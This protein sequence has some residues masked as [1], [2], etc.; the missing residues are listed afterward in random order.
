MVQV[1]SNCMQA[2]RKFHVLAA[3]PR[4]PGC[5]CSELRLLA[6]LVQQWLTS[7]WS[8]VSLQPC[9]MPAVSG[10]PCDPSTLVPCTFVS[11]QT[12]DLSLHK[13]SSFTVSSFIPFQVVFHSLHLLDPTRQGQ[14]SWALQSILSTRAADLL[15]SPKHRNSCARQPC[16]RHCKGS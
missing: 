10:C 15:I 12:E 5:V 6:G 7:G 3:Q 4:V 1:L 2:G 9:A 11:G 16:S 13:C 8:T 14:I